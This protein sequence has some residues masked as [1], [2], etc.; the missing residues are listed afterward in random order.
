MTE[1]EAL[2]MLKNECLMTF[3]RYPALNE[4]VKTAMAALEKQI[5]KKPLRVEKSLDYNCPRCGQCCGYVDCM[6]WDTPKFCVECGQALG[7]ENEED[8]KN[9]SMQKMYTFEGGGDMIVLIEIV[10]HPDRVGGIKG[11]AGNGVMYGK[12]LNID[13]KDFEADPMKYAAVLAEGVAEI[14]RMERE[15]K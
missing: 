10:T 7:W 6:S 4:A 14:I 11:T 3:Y 2:K 15:R 1:A 12:V 5:P 13:N 8:N 9:D